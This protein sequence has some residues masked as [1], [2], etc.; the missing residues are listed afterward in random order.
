MADH[1][2]QIIRGFPA[3]D[4]AALPSLTDMLR[5]YAEVIAPWANNAAAT[6]L[7]EVNQSDISGWRKLAGAMSASVQKEILSAPTGEVFRLLQASQ[8]E[9]IKSIPLDAA[10][11]VHDLT[12]KGLE[13]GARAKEYIAEIMRS[14]EVAKS[15][16]MLIAR[17]EVSRASSNF[18]QARAEAVGSEHY[19]W[20]T[21]H[22]GDVRS[23]HKELDG[24]PFA[25]SEP[26]IAD[27]RSGAR[28]HPGAIYNCF[29]GWE[30]V[31]LSP[32]IRK[33]IRA[34]FD[35]QVVDIGTSSTTI[36]AT[37]NHP[38]LTSRGWLPVCEI[39]EGDYLLQSLRDAV[40]IV[41]TNEDV[42]HST[43]D[44]LF[45]AFSEST[46]TS[47]G[48][49]FDFYGDVSND[50]IDVSAVEGELTADRISERLN[51]LRDF[52]FSG[53]DAVVGRIGLYAKHMGNPSGTRESPSFIEGQS[54]HSDYVGL[55][56]GSDVDASLR[57]PGC[58]SD[59]RNPDPL[60]D[61]QDA[62][63]GD[64][65]IYSIGEVGND[66]VMCWSSSLSSGCVDSAISKFLAENV[67]ANADSGGSVF[68]KFAVTHQGLRVVNLCS[69]E[70]SGHVFTLETKLGWYEVSSSNIIARNCRCFAD[71]IIPD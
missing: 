49:L 46:E 34:K 8:V 6:M 32:G 53:S 71:P 45:L 37:L 67:G 2:G 22:D 47:P 9:L 62:F 29:P 1:V 66:P 11:R 23:D 5:R 50:E 65:C 31:R 69:R 27:K 19:I 57:K 56:S 51:S 16:A 36:T 54:L 52:N 12:I 38:V 60:G 42:T 68:D 7:G 59:P 18:T 70:F 61:R 44:D 30:K 3:G 20:R 4:P 35:G 17:T 21:S 15:R 24:K 28:A 13:D 33:I 26:P 40:D 41:E 10:Q 63:A 43:F 48:V 58:K 25:W 39:K 14:G 64:V 55:A